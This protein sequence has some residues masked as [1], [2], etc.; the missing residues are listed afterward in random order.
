VTGVTQHA[1]ILAA[2]AGTR[3]LPFTLD[4]PKCFARIGRLMI[5]E[6]QLRAL[7]D[8]GC[9]H[10]TIVTGHLADRIEPAISNRYG[11]LS[12]SY[13]YND[14]YATT[15][16][17]YSLALGLEGLDESTWVLEGDVCLEAVTLRKS[18][19]PVSWLV[20]ASL[21]QADG[22]H[23]ECDDN[24][25]ARTV[26]ILR[27]G[28]ISAPTQMKSVGALHL[29]AEGAGLVARWLSDGIQ[30]GRHND[31]YDLI[32]A[33]HLDEGAIRGIDVAPAPWFEVDTAADLE[34]ARRRFA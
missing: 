18:E 12:V 32:L 6:H 5:I 26:S 14:R 30:A 7:A 1:I 29:T 20:D 17:M 8:V 22:S 2:G 24:G 16:S 28:Q 19:A 3:L 11:H 31:Y 13:V 23:L 21:R 33:D 4:Q 27:N 9:R 34:E 10:A 25:V 15:N